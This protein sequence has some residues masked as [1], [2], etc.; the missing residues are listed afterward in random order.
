MLSWYKGGPR[1]NPDISQ[2]KKQNDRND[3]L[4]WQ[5][6]GSVCGDGFSVPSPQEDCDLALAHLPVASPW[7][8]EGQ[9]QEPGGQQGSATSAPL[10]FK[11]PINGSGAQPG[12]HGGYPQ[13]E[14]N[15]C[16]WEP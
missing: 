6:K 2:V 8:M 16:V 7:Y 11:V 4:V 14:R 12:T 13:K 1:F 15:Q 5:V 9:A 10:V 3:R